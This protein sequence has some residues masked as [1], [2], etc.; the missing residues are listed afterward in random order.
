MFF[1]LFPHREDHGLIFGVQTKR[2]SWAELDRLRRQF[3]FRFSTTHNNLF[4][5]DEFQRRSSGRTTTKLTNRRTVQ[6]FLSLLVRNNSVFCFYNYS[7]SWLIMEELYNPMLWTICLSLLVLLI[8]WRGVASFSLLKDLPIPGPS[9]WP[10]LGNLP[11]VIKYG[12]MHN[13]L[14]EYFQRY[15]RVY[16]MGFGR[17]PTIVVA[18]PEMIRQITIKEFPK[19]QNRWFPEVNSPMNSFLFIA[20]DD[21][22]KRIRTTLSPTFSAMKLKEVIPIME[23]AANIMTAKLIDAANAGEKILV[24]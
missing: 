20:K 16:K 8:Y 5:I 24:T 11:D 10:Y 23:E 4:E 14:W 22:W 13:M 6:S 3:P 17:R 21:Q 12:G 18:D 15:G 2:A 19:F 1:F 9:Q 7:P